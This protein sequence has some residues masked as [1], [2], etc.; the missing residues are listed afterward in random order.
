[1]SYLVKPHSETRTE[2]IEN[3]VRIEKKYSTSI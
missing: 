1:M 3:K 2:N